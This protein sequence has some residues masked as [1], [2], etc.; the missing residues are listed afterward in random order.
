MVGIARMREGVV[1]NGIV[2]AATMK[3][4]GQVKEG[5]LATG[6]S[7]IDGRAIRPD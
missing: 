3:R 2:E 4:G 7:Y 5:F 1:E 6:N